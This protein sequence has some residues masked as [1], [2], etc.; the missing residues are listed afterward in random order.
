MPYH[1]YVTK[2][3]FSKFDTYGNTLVLLTDWALCN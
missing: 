1:R 2:H 3:C